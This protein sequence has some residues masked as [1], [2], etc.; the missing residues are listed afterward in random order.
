MTDIIETG[1]WWV[2]EIESS[3][4]DIEPVSTPLSLE[5]L[6]DENYVPIEDDYYSEEYEEHSTYEYT[7]LKQEL[8]DITHQ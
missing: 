8:Y 5:E 1:F 2:A 4:E 6:S 3:Q 7:E